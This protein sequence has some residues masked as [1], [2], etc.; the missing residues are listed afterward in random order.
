MLQV[1]KPG[2]EGYAP[3]ST[4][5][6]ADAGSPSQWRT[7]PYVALSPMSSP[8]DHP[9]LPDLLPSQAVLGLPGRGRAGL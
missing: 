5:L 7:Q 9:S 1:V 2:G 6:S 4:R 3:A 8:G